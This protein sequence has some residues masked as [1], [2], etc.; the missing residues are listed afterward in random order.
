MNNDLDAFKKMI[1]ER[2]RYPHHYR[3]FTI[4]GQLIITNNIDLYQTLN[5]N[6][7]AMIHCNSQ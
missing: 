6:P 3:G 1:K 4:I 5:V 2:Y 7:K